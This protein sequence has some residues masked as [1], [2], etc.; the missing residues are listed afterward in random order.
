VHQR[1]NFRY[2]VRCGH[3]LFYFPNLIQCLRSFI[4]CFRIGVPVSFIPYSY[5]LLIT[6]KKKS[7]TLAP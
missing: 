4:S 1:R 5:A 3:A 7:N 2:Q 6:V